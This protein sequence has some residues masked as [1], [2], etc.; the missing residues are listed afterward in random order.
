MTFHKVGTIDRRML[1]H[2]EDPEILHWAANNNRILLIYD[3]A[4]I[5]DLAYPRIIQGRRTAG[6]STFG[7]SIL[8][9]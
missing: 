2:G 6:S 5:P 4:T 3:R 9:R 8:N 1:E 7:T